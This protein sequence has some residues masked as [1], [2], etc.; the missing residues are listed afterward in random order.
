MTEVSDKLKWCCKNGDLDATKALFDAGSVS[1]A[2]AVI[3]AGR[4]AIHFAADMG[5]ANI[6]EYLVSKGATVDLKDG[7]GMTPILNAI[8]EGHVE[9]VQA[10]LAAGADK[11]GKTPG[12]ESYLE[13]ADTAE[14]RIDELKAALA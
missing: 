14:K 3:G 2:N 13:A 11:A 10:L 5:Q 7:N 4:S 9:T 6:V 8:Y 1:D 12:G